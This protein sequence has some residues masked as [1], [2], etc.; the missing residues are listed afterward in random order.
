MAL[1]VAPTTDRARDAPKPSGAILA[2]QEKTVMMKKT[3]NLDAVP[4]KDSKAAV[5][6]T[7]TSVDKRKPCSAL[8]P[9]EVSTEC[10]PSMSAKSL[11]VCGPRNPFYVNYGSNADPLRTLNTAVLRVGPTRGWRVA[12]PHQWLSREHAYA[13]QPRS[14][15]VQKDGSGGCS[16][17]VQTKAEKPPHQRDERPSP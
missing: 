9:L 12:A 17:N 8:E 2:H 4:K 6:I 11:G 16:L 15:A 3:A 1:S 14:R 10:W 5:S 7:L 13:R